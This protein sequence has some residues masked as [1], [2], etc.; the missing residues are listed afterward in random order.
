[1]Q[2][3]PHHPR[4]CQSQGHRLRIFMLNFT[5][6]FL[7]PHYYT[8]P[9]NS[10]GVLWLHVGCPSIH[11]SLI[12]WVNISGFS[13]DLIC[14][15]IL[16]RSGLGLLLG[17]FCQFLTVICPRHAYIFYSF[18]DNNF[19][20]CWWIFTKLAGYYAC[21]AFIFLFDW[22]AQVQASYPVWRQ[23]LFSFFTHIFAWFMT[24]KSRCNTA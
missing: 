4:S 1:M 21:S 15:L 18:P 23:V 13:P 17:K 6:K 8:P 24:G 7:R 19:N 12:I 16:W 3:H 9:Q 10:G 14:V 5:S 20:K 2:Y 22:Q 11:L